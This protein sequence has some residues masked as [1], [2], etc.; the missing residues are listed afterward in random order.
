MTWCSW[1]LARRDLKWWMDESV[2]SYSDHRHIRIEIAD[3]TE[4]GR[5][6]GPSKLAGWNFHK[7][8]VDRLYAVIENEF[9]IE[10][11]GVD[12]PGTAE[13]WSARLVERVTRT[14]NAAM[15]KR[16]TGTRRYA[17]WWNEEIVRLRVEAIRTGRKSK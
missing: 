16:F 12:T 14:C 4:R 5:V 15:P 3:H 8:N 9:W 2:E 1:R 13:K 7:L 10:T 17:Y 11:N 6:R